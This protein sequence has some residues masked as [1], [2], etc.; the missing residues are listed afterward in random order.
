MYFFYVL[1][2][3]EPQHLRQK[4]NQRKQTKGGKNAWKIMERINKL[5]LLLILVGL[6][7]VLLVNPSSPCPLTNRLR[8]FAFLRCLLV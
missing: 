3:F 7:V 1:V 6:A 2:T 4:T 8:I 5:I